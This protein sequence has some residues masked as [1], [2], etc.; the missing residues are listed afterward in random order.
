MGLW[1]KKFLISSVLFLNISSVFAIGYQP[2]LSL[3]MAKKMAESCEKLAAKEGWKINIAIVD[4][5]ANLK[6]FIRQDDSFLKS[7]EVAKQKATTSAGLPFSTKAIADIASKLPGVALIPG[8]SILE[9]GLPIVTA[10]GQ[11]IGAIGVSG[12]TGEQDGACAQAGLDAIQ[13]D[14]K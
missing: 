5:G 6:F 3:S 14:L 8:V 2:V 13:N 10:K 11:L 1:M 4:N 7:I 9:G 12:A